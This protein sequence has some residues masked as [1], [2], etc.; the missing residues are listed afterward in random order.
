LAIFAKNQI[1]ANFMYEKITKTGNA[2]YEIDIKHRNRFQ[3]GKT[4]GDTVKKS[5]SVRVSL[6]L[7]K[8]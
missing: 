2:C 6:R 3:D 1:S 8:K 7:I 5:V 4:R